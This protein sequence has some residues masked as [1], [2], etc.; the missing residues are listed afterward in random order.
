MAYAIKTFSL[1]DFTNNL[2]ISNNKEFV[3]NLI[4]GLTNK[5][6]NF[7]LDFWLNDLDRKELRKKDMTN[8]SYLPKCYDVVAY[9]YMT[10]VY[11]LDLL[12][13][14]K[15][16]PKLA[17]SAGRA[18]NNLITNN[19]LRSL[20]SYIDNEILANN[21][22]VTTA[23]IVAM[24][25][26]GFNKSPIIYHKTNYDLLD[27]FVADLH[28]VNL[29]HQVNIYDRCPNI[30]A[31]YIVRQNKT[32]KLIKL[33]SHMYNAFEKDK[34]IELLDFLKIEKLNIL[35]V[36]LNRCYMCGYTPILYQIIFTYVIRSMLAW[37]KGRWLNSKNIYKYL[38]TFN[39]QDPN[40]VDV[41]GDLV[42]YS[43][44]ML[45]KT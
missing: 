40:I 2:C 20:F 27:K 37:Q 30:D 42:E 44:E 11:S 13:S 22:T 28:K 17:S 35:P 24:L 5:K 26:E 31:V 33:C 36:I 43:T 1:S 41:I 39:I 19:T 16:I 34:L 25:R 18:F 3:D 6:V 10:N 32:K 14:T 45:I 38:G 21:L 9:S 29:F 8:Y 4:I 12:H 23:N 7:L 15:L